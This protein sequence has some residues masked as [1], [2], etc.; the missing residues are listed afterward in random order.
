MNVNPTDLFVKRST[1]PGAGLGLFTKKPIA[2]G[3]LIAEY[4]GRV[5]TWKEV[6]HQNG[7]NPYIL[8][9]NR[10]HVID[11]LPYKKSLARFANDARGFKKVRGKTNNAIY[12]SFGKSVFIQATRKIP[13]RS[14]IFVSYGKEYWDTMKYNQSI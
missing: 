11:A 1:I 3:D 7:T 6:E 13:A 8:Y 5:S 9:L 12:V 14:E 4:K 2:K 10:Q